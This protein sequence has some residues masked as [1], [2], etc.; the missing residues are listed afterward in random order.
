MH[1]ELGQPSEGFEEVDLLGDIIAVQDRMNELPRLEDQSPGS[2]RNLRLDVLGLPLCN[3]SYKRKT[4]LR[5]HLTG[6]FVSPDWHHP[7]GDP[8]WQD[9]VTRELMHVFTRP[10]LSAEERRQRAKQSTQRCWQKNAPT[11]K[12]NARARREQVR[13]VLSLASKLKRGGMIVESSVH[14]L[15]V[16]G[17]YLTIL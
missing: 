14:F 12:Q 3:T 5:V 8:T 17:R 1:I 7:L 13:E 15:R 9:E 6:R 11:Y 16:V 10:G 4:T 2:A